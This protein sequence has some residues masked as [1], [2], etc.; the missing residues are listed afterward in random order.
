[1]KRMLTAAAAIVGCWTGLLAGADATAGSQGPE[2]V[3]FKF[4]FEPGR[5]YRQRITSNSAG[6]LAL[7]APLAEQKFRQVFEQ[8]LT[9]TCRKVNADGSA[10]FDL[11]LSDVAMNMSVGGFKMEY[12]SRTF[13]PKTADP[14]L[15]LVG[16]FFEAMNGVTFSVTLSDT[17]RPLKVEGLA[18]GMKKALNRIEAQAG[19]GEMKGFFD[20][21]AGFMDDESMNQQMQSYYRMAPETP[22]PVKV[23]E[24]WSQTWAMKMPFVGGSFEG[25]G[26]YELLGIEELQGRRCAKIRVKESFKMQPRAAG[27]AAGAEGESAM[28]RMLAGL[29]M[30][31]ST[32]GGD[33][34]AYIDCLRGELVRLRQTQTMT[35][36]MTVPTTDNP[37]G[38]AAVAAPSFTMNIRTSVSIDT[39]DATAEPATKPAAGPVR[40]VRRPAQAATRPSGG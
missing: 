40:A 28:A 8:V 1:M 3:E 16:R 13:D 12:D 27:A 26:D 39:L 11:T 33:G 31:L 34:I 14:A 30:E 6:A 24:K 9:S 29:K 7:P 17:G 10:V 23:G 5:T 2:Q 15:A 25:R 18:A 35:I 21:L 32:S 4:K 38:A 22:G 36:G 37:E 20:Q 19:G